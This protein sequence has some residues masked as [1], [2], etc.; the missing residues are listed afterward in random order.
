MA[1]TRNIKPDDF[2]DDALGAEDFPLAAHFLRV[3]LNCLA[4]K[5][6]RLE[7]RPQKIRAQVFPYRTSLDVE[8]LLAK[9]AQVNSIRRYSVGGQRF[10]Q[11]VGFTEAQN[12]HPNEAKSRLPGPELHDGGNATPA[13]VITGAIQKPRDD[14]PGRH[15]ISDPGSLISDQGPPSGQP[16][17][18]AL[19][20]VTP[21][22]Q[23]K[24]KA[25]P[26]TS[27]E[28]RAAREM[29]FTVYQRHRGEE[30]P[31]RAADWGQ[32]REC[33]QKAGGDGAVLESRWDH[34]LAL[35]IKWPGCSTLG[36]LSSKWADVLTSWK[37]S[38]RRAEPAKGGDTEYTP[39][40][41]KRF[42]ENDTQ[43]AQ[44]IDLFGIR[45]NGGGG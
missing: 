34:A 42:W 22:R 8:D 23:P 29:V 44:D 5:E 3:G 30:Y 43:A 18:P 4:D 28:E 9:L 38:A 17:Q 1:R 7:D 10:I 37:E 32:L 41:E 24:K 35:G 21:T 16:K 14:T 40:P 45:K 26:A 12:P 13:H 36:Q 20:D 25:E 33:L 27:P 15:L 2:L 19:V 39:L 31:W 11:L 6:G